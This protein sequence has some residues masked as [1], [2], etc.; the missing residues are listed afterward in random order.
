MEGMSEPKIGPTQFKAEVERLQR[1][2]KMPTLEAVLAAV[3]VSVADW[4]TVCERARE[5]IEAQ[6]PIDEKR[7]RATNVIDNTGT[8]EST[9]AQ[10]ETLW[11]ALSGA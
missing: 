11:E 2:G 1:E 7:S 4:K 6:M 9:R 3:R 5:V 10:V 8:R